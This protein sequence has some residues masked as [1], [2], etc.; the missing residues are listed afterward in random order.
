MNLPVIVA[1]AHN[2]S[3]LILG[4]RQEGNLRR[5]GYKK[6]LFFLYFAANCSCSY[7]VVRERLI[8]ND[9][10]RFLDGVVA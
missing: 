8:F 3:T 9:D 2:E 5:R 6:S 1:F 7:D 10:L 4:A